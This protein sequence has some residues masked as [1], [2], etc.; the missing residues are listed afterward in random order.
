MGSR[1]LGYIINDILIA[2]YIL[3][4]LFRHP[5]MVVSADHMLDFFRRLSVSIDRPREDP[6]FAADRGDR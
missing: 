6:P 5:S 1:R 3:D 4:G 2:R